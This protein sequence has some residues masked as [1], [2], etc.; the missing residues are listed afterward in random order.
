MSVRGVAREVRVAPG[1]EITV[2]LI[3]QEV[4]RAIQQLVRGA[5][6]L[7][8]TIEIGTLKV[9]AA[10]MGAVVVNVSAVTS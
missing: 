1:E 6:H 8:E 9:E 4:T 3:A 5:D 10:V 7:G 2:E